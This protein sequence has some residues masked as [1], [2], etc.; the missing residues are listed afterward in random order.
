MYKMLG[1]GAGGSGKTT[2]GISSFWDFDNYE[3]IDKG[4]WIRLGQERN[5]SLRVPDEFVQ[6]FA[7]DP[8]KPMNF[9]GELR[10]YL[11]ALQVA[12]SKGQGP[13]WLVFDGMT[14]LAYAASFA[15]N[16]APLDPG[17]RWGEWR[18]QKETVG[19]IF[20]LL[21]ADALNC[22]I[23]A[24]AR[25]GEFRKGIQNKQSGAVQGRDPEWLSDQK[26]FPQM[27]GWA[28][29]NLI[30]YFE[31]VFYLEEEASPKKGG[32][33]IHRCHLITNGDF[34]V[35]NNDSHR[36]EAKKL[37][38]WVDNPRM[39]DIVAILEKAGEPTIMESKTNYAE[40]EK[41]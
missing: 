32:M 40:K 25:I 3:V 1:Y 14:E 15:Y 26:Y 7:V 11:K 33:P 6:R 37:P 39:S 38:I 16:L 2:L 35:K 4:I 13:N 9:V 10:E 23:F 34:K 22:N 36:W 20:Q 19:L 17:D 30:S 18:F 5:D 27:D 24:T 41:V 8:A 21:D 31:Y 28:R 12:G 29:H